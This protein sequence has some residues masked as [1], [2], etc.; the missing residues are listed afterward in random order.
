MD[1]KKQFQKQKLNIDAH[2]GM[3]QGAKALKGALGAITAVAVLFKN[4]QNLK[5]LGEGTLK[6]AGQLLKK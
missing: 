5:A 2:R 6:I 1:E 3:E 4:R